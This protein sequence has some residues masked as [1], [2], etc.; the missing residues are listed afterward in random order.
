MI[1]VPS[2]CHTSD[3]EWIPERE[4]LGTTLHRMGYRAPEFDRLTFVRVMYRH[5]HQE[6][7]PT[8]RKMHW[9]GATHCS[10]LGNI[11]LG[12]ATGRWRIVTKN[13]FASLPP[14]RRC[15]VC[16]EQYVATK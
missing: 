7:T 3:R 5:E 16:N 10:T 8:I 2:A 14:G 9:D 13:M 4:P 15:V 6:P 12:K 11:K 1:T